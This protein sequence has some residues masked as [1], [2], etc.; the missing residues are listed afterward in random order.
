MKIV[1]KIKR[2]PENSIISRGFGKIDYCDSYRIFKSTNDSIDTILTEVYKTPKW[3]DFLMSLRDSIVKIFGLKTDDKNNLN[4]TGFY[5][6]GS[7]AAAF[8]V[9][10]RNED[11]IVMFE[12]DKH[13]N[14]RTS[15]FID[16]HDEL[17]ALYM[18]T[19]V[20][21]NNVWGKLYFIPVKPLHQLI[22]KTLLNKYMKKAN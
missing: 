11:E 19:I 21:F 22:V 7:K 13:L 2:V 18:T 10:D 9:L 4:N 8:I 14:Y 6:V 5:S 3:I 12:D 20:Q 1:H 17:P 16:R 15:I